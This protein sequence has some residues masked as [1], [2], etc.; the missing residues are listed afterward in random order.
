[1]TSTKKPWRLVGCLVKAPL[2]CLAFLVGALV[3]LVIFLPPAIGNLLRI[4]LEDEFAERY[5]GSLEFEEVWFGSFYGD[6]RV[7]GMALSD[8]D[9]RPILQ[10][11]MRAPSLRPLLDEEEWG[12][13]RLH[14]TDV[15]LVRDAEGLTNLARALSRESQEG[16][17]ST[18][19][20]LFEEDAR[21]G[22]LD[23]DLVVDRLSWS[24]VDGPALV[25]ENVRCS[26]TFSD[27]GPGLRMKATGYGVFSESGAAPGEVF[28]VAWEVKDVLA[29]L[30]G[31][32]TWSFALEAKRAPSVLLATFFRSL[33]ELQTPL[34]A[35][36][37][38]FKLQLAGEPG[39]PRRVEEL[40]AAGP[41][42][43]LDLRA[44]W[45]AAEGLLVGGADDF[46]VFRLPATSES[47]LELVR[48]ALPLARDVGLVLPAGVTEL[49]LSDFR[50][51]LGGDLDELR[52]TYE[53]RAEGATFRL[54]DEL[55][56]RFHLGEQNRLL[57][58]RAVRLE[59]GEAH[60]D[61]LAF[62]GKGGEILVSGS[63]RF[64]DGSYQLVFRLPDF[65]AYEVGGTESELTVKLLEQ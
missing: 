29:L 22:P 41:E 45:H 33:E 58:T 13:I 25:V 52:A 7:E 9:G 6:Q 64:V 3:V 8:P 35:E 12:P 44:E 30:S 53:L 47:A 51:P 46:A 39:E 23:L 10:G 18:S 36:L 32:T 60:Y 63:Y 40:V 21:I 62:A 34:G 61:E 5:A 43:E 17:A 20:S 1:M 49:H 56:E 57:A 54:P 48:T 27:T 19:V 4:S 2:G 50:L 15:E 38:A 42:L 37:S 14:L 28:G 26:V 59:A 24:E 16:G 31:E 65:S 55:S 11:W